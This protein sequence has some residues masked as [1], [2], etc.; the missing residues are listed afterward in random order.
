MQILKIRTERLQVA[1]M[2]RAGLD[3]VPMFVATQTPTCSPVQVTI[4]WLFGEQIVECGAVDH[5]VAHR[6]KE[7]RVGEE[8]DVMVRMVNH[9]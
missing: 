7:L 6:R 8:R 1:L 9:G 5:N 3:T 2:R 4:L